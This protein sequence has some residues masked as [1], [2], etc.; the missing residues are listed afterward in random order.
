VLSVLEQQLR[1]QGGHRDVFE[2]FSEGFLVVVVVHRDF[3]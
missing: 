1:A 2:V 3:V